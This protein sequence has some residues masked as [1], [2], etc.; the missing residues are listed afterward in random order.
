[1]SRLNLTLACLDYDRVKPLLTRTVEPAGIDLNILTYSTDD[2]VWPMI[3]HQE[4]DVS[5]MTLA[6]YTV[7]RARGEAPF[8]AIPVFLARTFIHGGLFVHADSGIK[9]PKDLEG[10]R[11]A[12][13][14]FLMSFAV[15]VRGLLQHE[16]G[17]DL[18]K[19]RWLTGRPEASLDLPPELRFDLLPEGKTLA[20][21]LEAGEFDA[22]IAPRVPPSYRK[23]GSAI[24]RLF[25]DPKSLEIAFFRRT[26]IFPILHLVVIRNDIYQRHPW[27]ASS[28][29]RAF[30]RARDQCYRDL[31]ETL[32]GLRYTVPWLDAAMDQVREVMGQDFWPYGLSRNRHV[33]ETYIGYLRDQHLLDRSIT[34]DELFAP[35]ARD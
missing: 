22:L 35:N 4:F 21:R 31:S 26:G 1:M 10:K 16:H 15:W 17:L 19:V 7:L 8:V 25:P 20:E 32:E 29:F 23:P 6:S 3:R 9:E 24:R 13:G 34:P 2:S 11:V 18:T 30:V 33:L 28:L 27:V 12:S 5:E 14:Q